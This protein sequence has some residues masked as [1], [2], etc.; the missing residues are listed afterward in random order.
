MFDL[1]IRR[2][3]VLDGLG[4][5]E[6]VADIGISEDTISEV[7]N[8]GDVQARHTLDAEGL[9]A[10]PGFVDMHT[11]SGLLYPVNPKAES[12][13]HQ[14]VTTE[15]IGHCGTS[16]APLRGDARKEA[17]SLTKMVNIDLDWETFEDYDEMFLIEGIA[18][19]VVHLLG[20][21]TLRDATIGRTDRHP[22]EEE[23]ERMRREI[24][25]AFE[26]GVYG[27]STG[28]IY[29]P[30]CYSSTAEL[31]ELSKAVARNGGIYSSHIR[32]EGETLL[33]AI[34]EAIE[35]GEC[36][37]VPVQISH[38][39][40]AGRKYWDAGPRAL[41]L[42]D[43]A[44]ETGMD[45]AADMYP[46]LAG[47]TG[48]ETLLPK[49]VHNQG[50]EALLAR[51][52]DP[53]ARTR[54]KKEMQKGG[55]EFDTDNITGGWDGVF[56]GLSAGHPEYQ[57]KTVRQISEELQKDPIDTVMDIVLECNCVAYMNVMTQS[58]DNVR[59][60]I[61]HPRV[62]IGSDAAAFAP[63]GLLGMAMPHPR[64]YGTFPRV[65]GKY[66]REEKI[67]TL[68]EAV[69][70]MTSLPASRLGLKDRGVVAPGKKA[71]LVL[72]DAETIIDRAVYEDP[73][74][75]PL[76]I[77]AVLVNG[78]IVVEDDEHSGALPGAVLRR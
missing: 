42:I 17:E 35:I 2:A 40:V 53:K 18:V 3:R 54:I 38:L 64:T 14:G 25:R 43:R 6:Y 66:V 67:L 48:L 22:T 27:M 61:Q 44:L 56:I 12:K 74:Q 78:K 8:I 63:Y 55:T 29:P 73:N 75:Y 62:M 30:G 60:F 65:L 5:D 59:L 11:H 58:E 71:D 70:K 21:G 28:L 32:G 36:A 51:L 50:N 37:G 69:R 33:K 9:H 76:G 49:W 20:H 1:L 72:F 68:P 77:K 47:S 23:I 7:G 31:I 24:D 26:Y 41:E 34:S 13:V 52:D 39:K 10:A 19:N 45:I 16:V 15:V 57:G 4:N 46:Y